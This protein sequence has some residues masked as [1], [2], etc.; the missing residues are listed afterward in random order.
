[1]SIGPIPGQIW[2]RTSDNTLTTAPTVTSS[3]VTLHNAIAGFIV[4][5]PG[6]A[7]LLGVS[8]SV[9]GAYSPAGSAANAFNG[10]TA[11]YFEDAA[12]GGEIITATFDV[13][14]DQYALIF[15][16]IGGAA[17][18]SLLDGVL[19]QGQAAPTTAQDAMTTGASAA[20]QNA[21]APGL[22]IALGFAQA[23]GVGVGTG[24]ADGGVFMGSASLGGTMRLESKRVTIPGVQQSATFKAGGNFPAVSMLM[25]LDELGASTGG[26]SGAARALSALG[27]QGG[28]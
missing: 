22:V 28:F 14:A 5:D 9:N 6:Q 24:F 16:E 20:S 8:G 1:M 17:L 25:V 19:G 15:Q 7:T 2:T 4:T 27:N 21:K 3:G 26:G 13:P 12:A 18:T 11:F 10:I 23:V